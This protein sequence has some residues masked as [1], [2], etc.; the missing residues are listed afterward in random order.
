MARSIFS[1][2]QRKFILSWVFLLTGYLVNAQHELDVIRG[3]WLHYNNTSNALYQHLSSEAYNLLEQRAQTV[4]GIQ[5]LDDWKKRQEWIKKTMMEAVGP[6]PEKTPL[7]AKTLRTIDK[8]DYKVE[9]IIFESQP[10]F[11]VT[12]TLFVPK[13]IKGKNKAPAILYCSG[14]ADEGY[15]IKVYQHVILNLVKKGFVVFAFDPVGQGERLE[16]FDSS[17]GKSS[18][19]GP[20]IEHSYPGAQ[21]FISGSSQ[22]RYMIWDG[23]RAIDYLLTRK[24]VDASRIGITGR[25]GGGTQTAYIAAMDDRIKASAPECYITSFTRLLQSIGPQDAEQNLFHGISLG[26]DQA[27]Y[28]TVR[29]PKPTLMITT[30]RDMFSIQGARETAKEVSGIYEAYGMENNFGIVED[31]APHESTRKNREAMYAFFQKQLNNPGNAMDEEATVL[32]A[33][34]IQVTKTGQVSTSPGGETVFSLNRMESQK[35]F[36]N[37]TTSRNDLTQHLPKVLEAAKELSGYREPLAYEVPVF[38]GR[39]NREGYSIEK[40]FMK[41]DGDYVI[42][43]LMMTPDK[44]NNKVILYIHPSGK[45][46]EA[47][48]GGEMEWFVKK[49][50]VVLAPDLIGT[51]E[52]SLSD[53]Q[54]DAFID[55]KSHNIWY[56]AML[57]GR[58]LVGIQAGDLVRLL[59][60]IKGKNET[61]KIYG[62]ARGEMTPVLMHAAAYDPT[63]ERVA[64][65]EPYSSYQSMVMNRFY[66]SMFIYGTVPG[67][68]RGYDLPD[69]LASLAPRKL[70]FAGITDHLGKPASPDVILQDMAIVKN[71]Y[72]IRNASEQLNILIGGSSENP[73]NLF[74]EW[75]K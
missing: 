62:V 28:L 36:S 21:A 71:S 47:A 50:F 22:A 46:V 55:G 20:T 59:R 63:I 13:S 65:I 3:N 29:A 52:M 74:S 73:A 6:F 68:L 45:A 39:I 66:N 17:T 40:Y 9:H 27:D 38:T 14:H 34:E 72:Q 23:I 49:G 7:S 60:M 8:G 48:P 31:D 54:G 4:S 1:G 26:L 16:Y 10:G 64:L 37:L 42:P 69:L 57:I 44:P 58:S 75:I 24:E 18:V 43:Y 41:G 67:S 15:R 32:T 70:L 33:E 11:Y 25:S 51:G 2:I 35:L 12:S 30:T 61:S 56:S 5:S 19:G 53:F